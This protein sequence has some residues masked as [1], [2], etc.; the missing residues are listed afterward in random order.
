MVFVFCWLDGV[1]DMI[2]I[3]VLIDDVGWVI[4]HKLDTIAVFSR[5]CVWYNIEVC[6]WFTFEAL[7]CQE[8]L[9]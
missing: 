7:H 6:L 9:R 2:Y 5:A 4:E 8:I 1:L 3:M